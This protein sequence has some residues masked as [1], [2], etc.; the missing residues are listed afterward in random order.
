M[1]ITTHFLLL[2]ESLAIKFD[3]TKKILEMQLIS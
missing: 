1:N 2:F 3:L